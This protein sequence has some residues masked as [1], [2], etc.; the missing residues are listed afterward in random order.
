MGDARS[1]TITKASP[2]QKLGI[3]LADAG[4]RG[5]KVH[6]LMPGGPLTANL[7]K[8]DVIVSINGTA[9][10]QG[11]GHAATLLRD[12]TTTITV[13]V[14][15]PKKPGFL[16]RKLSKKSTSACL[17]YTSPSPRDS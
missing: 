13:V 8:G 10:N 15:A 11:H 6:E 7:S 2:D 17:L 3:R 9:C 1:F 4:K 5:V 12:A 14:G 16:A